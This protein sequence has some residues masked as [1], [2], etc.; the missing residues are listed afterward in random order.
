MQCDR[1]NAHAY[2]F[3]TLDTGG[4]LSWCGHHYRQHEEALFAYAIEVVDERHLLE[5]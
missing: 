2:V 1:C 4:Q 5:A 3:V